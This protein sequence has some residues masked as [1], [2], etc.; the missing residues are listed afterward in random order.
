MGSTPWE[1]SGVTVPTY[2]CV[3]SDPVSLGYMSIFYLGGECSLEI[4]DHVE[5][6][7]WV[8]D[9]SDPGE[10]DQYCVY[11]NGSIGGAVA[12]AGDCP[13]TPVETVTWGSIKAMYR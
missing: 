3:S 7:R 6:P 11:M 9:C 4:L 2:D 8:V 13:G 12:A 1:F 5:Y 10:I